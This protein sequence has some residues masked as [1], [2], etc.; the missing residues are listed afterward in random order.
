MQSSLKTE[1]LQSDSSLKSKKR[2]KPYKRIPPTA[3][4]PAQAGILVQMRKLRFEPSIAEAEKDSRLGGNDGKN[5][6]IN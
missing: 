3:V 6:L 4:I 5:L 2:L 1:N